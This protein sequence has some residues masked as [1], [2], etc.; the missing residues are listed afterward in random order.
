MPSCPPGETGEPQA[1]GVLSQTAE[2][3]HHLELGLRALSQ[4]QEHGRVQ[5]LTGRQT[6][7]TRSGKRI[8]LS[9]SAQEPG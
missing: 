1:C 3:T 8:S 2:D 4:R 9:V 6:T 5:E 7:G